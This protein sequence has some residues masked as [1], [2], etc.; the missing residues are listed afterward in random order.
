MLSYL[1]PVIFPDEC[2]VL[3]VSP[4]RYVYPIFKN[5]SSSLT[6]TPGVIVLGNDKIKDLDL[7]EVFVRNPFE[8]YISGVQTYL[9]HNSEYHLDTTLKIINEYLFLNRHFSLQF[10]WLV[11]LQ[12]YTKAK[13][14]LL[15]IDELQSTT[16]LFYNVQKQQQW[17]VDYFQPNSKLWYYLQL[18]KVLTEYFIGQTVQFQDILDH[19]QISYPDLYKEVIQR[20]RNLCAVL[21]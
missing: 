18:D 3:E 10:H 8:R 17:L 9:K 1:D 15:P 16:N 14:H 12:R 4:N 5:G 11:N 6:N 20:S 19:I 21:D 7:I 2:V 13:L